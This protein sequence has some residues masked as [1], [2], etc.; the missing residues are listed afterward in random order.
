MAAAQLVEVEQRPDLTALAREQQIVRHGHFL[1]EEHLEAQRRLGRALHHFSLLRLELFELCQIDLLSEQLR[2]AL[3][4]DGHEHAPGRVHGHAPGAPLSEQ[5][6]VLL[7][8]QHLLQV[9]IECAHVNGWLLARLR[10]KKA[11]ARSPLRFHERTARV[12]RQV[13]S[14]RH[15]ELH[16]VHRGRENAVVGERAHAPGYELTSELQSLLRVQMHLAQ[17]HDL[18]AVGRHV[19]LEMC[20]LR[21]LH[22]G[23][24]A[25]LVRVL[26]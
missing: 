10:L 5:L 12:R 25:A 13:G 23:R 21:L 16:V 22:V 15:R 8:D 20:E 26:A 14:D 7:G 11:C 1:L 19:L 18:V 2:H 3:L 24:Q 17:A 9:E 4:V 6:L